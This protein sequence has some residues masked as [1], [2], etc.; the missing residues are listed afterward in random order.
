MSQGVERKVPDLSRRTAILLMGLALVGTAASG[1]ATAA[2][3]V[4]EFSALNDSDVSGS[5]TLTLEDERLTVKIHA[6]QAPEGKLHSLHIHGYE[7]DQDALCPPSGA[8]TNG[9]GVI[10]NS[11]AMAFYGPLIVSVGSS[12]ASG[13]TIDFRKTIELGSDT[14]EKEDLLPL[15]KRVVVVH[16]GFVGVNYELLLPIACCTLRETS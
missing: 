14:V 16:G 12:Q 9:D 3:F 13:G 15:D 1:Q 11:E 7:D 5:V 2:R 10:T 6:E 4:G 8:D